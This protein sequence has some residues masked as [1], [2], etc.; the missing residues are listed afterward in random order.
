MDR[1]SWHEMLL[2][3]P[4][5]RFPDKL[6][7]RSAAY[8]R[9][10][11]DQGHFAFCK[12]QE[13]RAA[14]GGSRRFHWVFSMTDIALDADGRSAFGVT[15]A[16]GCLGGNRGHVMP[17]ISSVSDLE[18]GLFAFWPKGRRTIRV[19]FVILISDFPSPRGARCCLAYRGY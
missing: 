18:P 10:A 13:Y 6:R 3:R 5:R 7:A 9:S 11:V 1:R 16:Y 17:A 2:R 19:F 12:P 4:Y 15:M 8:C 14:L